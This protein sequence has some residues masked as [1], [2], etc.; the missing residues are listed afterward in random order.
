LRWESGEDKKTLGWE[1][2]KVV[3]K[4]VS[5]R[6]MVSGKTGKAGIFLGEKFGGTVTSIHHIYKN[7]MTYLRLCH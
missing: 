7:I 1:N 4:E 6:R 5:G 2:G 3:G